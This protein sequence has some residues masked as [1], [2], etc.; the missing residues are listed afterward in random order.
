VSLHLSPLAACGLL[1][2]TGCREPRAWAAPDW[3]PAAPPQRIVAASLLSAEVLL[4]IAPRERIAGV[5]YLAADPRYSVLGSDVAG[6][7]LVGAAAEQLLAASPD[8]VICDPFTKPE[9]LA[10]LASASVPV[11]TPRNP[12]T[13]DDVAANVLRIGSVCHLDG[14][15]AQL[16][17]KM[18]QRLAALAAHAGEVAE[19]RVVHVAGGMHVHGRGSLFDAVVAAAGARNVAAERGAG[20]FRKLDVE[21]LIGW[22]PDALVIGGTDGDVLPQWL[23]QVPGVALLPCVA[24]RRTLRIPEPLLGSTSHR[25]VEAA[26][27]LQRALRDWGRP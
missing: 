13:F 12:A 20:P 24:R 27:Q 15:A 7:P 4:A 18:R 11:V 23:Q 8:L 16:V 26:E 5:H 19:W 6:L 3:R 10:L 1:A 2:L 21:T 22:S 9:T 14:A 17:A 25:L